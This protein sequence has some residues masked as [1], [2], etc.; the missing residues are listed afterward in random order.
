MNLYFNE[1]PYTFDQIRSKTFSASSKKN[2]EVPNS[3]LFLKSSPYKRYDD[4]SISVFSSGLG[5]KQNLVAVHQQ[6]FH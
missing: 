6:A 5:V 3:I 1:K 4:L 2:L